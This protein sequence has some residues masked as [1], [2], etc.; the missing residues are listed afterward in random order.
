LGNGFG[1]DDR[2]LICELL[3]Q[4]R[5]EIP[6]AVDDYPLGIFVR[7]HHYGQPDI[8]VDNAQWFAASIAAARAVIPNLGRMVRW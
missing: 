1:G 4:L 5:S 3:I 6:I 7:G 2:L 8:V